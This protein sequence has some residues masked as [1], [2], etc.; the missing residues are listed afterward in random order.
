MNLDNSTQQRILDAKSNGQEVVVVLGLG[1]VGTA[2]IA[3]LARTTKNNKPMFF[4]IGLDQNTP[5]GREKCARLN[6]GL[7]PVYASDDSLSGVIAH[8]HS[9]Y[10]NLMGA[11]DPEV[12]TYADIVVFC[13]NLDLERKTGQ[14]DQL[15][16]NTAGYAAAMKMV[17]SKIPVGTL[18]TVESTL[19]LGMCDTVLYPALCEGQKDQGLDPKQ[20]PPLLAFCYERVMPG[21]DYLDSVNNFWRSIAGINEESLNRAEEFLS[22]F[23]N[24]KEYPIWKHK[25]TRAAEMSKLLENAYRATNIAFIEEWAKLAEQAGVDMFDVVASV[26]VRK[27]TH[28]NMMRPGLGVGGYC[29]T[30]DAL[31]AAFGAENLLGIDAEL[32]FSRK[33][34]LTNDNM[35]LRAIEWIK[36]HFSGNLSGKKTLLMGVTYRPGVA[37]TR[38]SATEIVARA[39]LS[40]GSQVIAYDQL[41]TEWEE[42]PE[43]TILE[44]I[45]DELSS[46]DAVVICLPDNYREIVAS[47]PSSLKAGSIVIDPWNMLGD[48]IIK[49][50][51]GRGISVKI[52]GR[53]DIASKN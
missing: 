10:R 12:L 37:D 34:I 32:P 41:V 30:K 4:V 50:L 33:A 11:V 52:Y 14:T 6:E 49:K 7:P 51:S 46:S 40:A 28:D 19:P 2:V 35:P 16:M 42:L 24:T 39:L 9:D 25:N 15:K 38:S 5:Q 31:L 43:V 53:G 18:V 44:N 47:F 36:Q 29:L 17:G 8:S 27:G 21:P 1:F 48:D 23:V 45:S 22:K 20:N 13:I 26:R 3:N